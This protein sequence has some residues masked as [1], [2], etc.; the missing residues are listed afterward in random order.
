MRPLGG[1]SETYNLNILIRPQRSEWH[2]WS[3][4]T[5]QSS[6]R[7]QWHVWSKVSVTHMI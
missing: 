1:L 4:Y 3:K 2:L 6:E 7:S 5:D